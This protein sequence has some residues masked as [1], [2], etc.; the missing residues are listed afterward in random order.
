MTSSLLGAFGMP[1]QPKP[2]PMN[3]NEM[4]PNFTTSNFYLA[5]KKL[6][7]EWWTFLKIR[8]FADPDV[9][10][11]CAVPKIHL[12][13]CGRFNEIDFFRLCSVFDHGLHG[14]Q[15]CFELGLA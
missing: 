5:K 1:P 10:D 4:I 11:F 9:I 2:L 3:R 14:R 13:I 8:L 15:V 12:K 6:T 7:H